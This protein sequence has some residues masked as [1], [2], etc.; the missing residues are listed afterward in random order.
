MFSKKRLFTLIALVTI[1]A[2]LPSTALAA[3]FTI[4][5][6]TVTVPGSYKSCTPDDTINFDNI[7]ATGS[8]VEYIFNQSND[9]VNWNAVGSGTLTAD[10]NVPFPYPNTI[11]G[12]MYFNV[13]IHVT[14]SQGFAVG[15]KLWNV[16][17]ESTPPPP[18][19][20]QDWGCSPGYWKNHTEYWSP[21][22][23]GTFYNAL[24]GGYNFDP[25]ITLLEALNLKGGGVYSDARHKVAEYLNTHAA[26]ANCDD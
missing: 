26:Y 15:Q 19:P 25:D 9:G 1:L 24:F 14:N 16:T 10:A 22:T 20:P 13:G 11:T 12:T 18:P 2:L 8:T 3:S 5:G 21:V 17:C 23:T 7:T 4:L 6:V